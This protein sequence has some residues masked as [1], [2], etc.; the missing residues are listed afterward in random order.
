M[1]APFSLS[2]TPLHRPSEREFRAIVETH[3]SRVYSIAY[4]ILGDGG[5]AEEVAQDV[6]LALYRDLD[7]DEDTF[8]SNEHMLAWLRRA[9]V[10]RA[11]DAHRRR[12]SRVDSIA[13]EFQEERTLVSRPQNGDS[14]SVSAALRVEQLV[15]SLPSI[16]RAIVLLRYQ[17]DM[18]PAEIAAALS[19]PLATVKSHLQRALRLLRTK[20][21]RQGKEVAHG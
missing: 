11:L 18:L 2:T 16:Q 4:R 10:H 17:E 6:F 13:E 5:L 19:M 9:A 14:S 12:A 15:R 7:R 21:E 1:K 3:Q 20:A 8:Q